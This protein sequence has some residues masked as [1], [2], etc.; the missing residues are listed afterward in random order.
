MRPKDDKN[1]NHRSRDD[2]LG[3]ANLVF[4]SERGDPEIP[5]VDDEEECDDN[6]K[7]R[8]SL[9]R[10]LEIFPR[11]FLTTHSLRTVSVDLGSEYFRMDL[12]KKL[13]SFE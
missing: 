4:F 6:E 3:F 10:Q 1:T 2:F 12:S 8:N 11:W 13:R 5:S 9:G 7:P